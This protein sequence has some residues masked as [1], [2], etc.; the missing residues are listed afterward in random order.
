LAFLAFTRLRRSSAATRLGGPP[1]KRGYPAHRRCWTQRRQAPHSLRSLG[2]TGVAA[3]A[4]GGRGV[5]PHCGHGAW[6]R[7]AP[8]A[9][10]A[11]APSASVR[12]PCGS[13]QSTGPGRACQRAK[14]RP[15]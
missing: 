6:G 7:L 11:A 2:V 8:L 3:L 10:V 4:L 14:T 13:P 9:L 1:R 5:A 15:P 12:I